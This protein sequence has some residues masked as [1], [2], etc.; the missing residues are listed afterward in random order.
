MHDPKA[1]DESDASLIEESP[2]TDHGEPAYELESNASI[3]DE[4]EPM[5]PPMGEEPFADPDGP[6]FVRAQNLIHEHLAPGVD[7]EFEWSEP[8]PRIEREPDR[9][10]RF[11][12]PERQPDLEAHLGSSEYEDEDEP[13][14]EVRILRAVPDES[15]VTALIADSNTHRKEV[16][17]RVS[18]LFPRPE[19]TEWSVKDVGYDRTRRAQPDMGDDAG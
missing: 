7:P 16:A 5:E 1:F 8:A 13:Q 19:T 18:L 12:L 6:Q 3:E 14:N 9:E 17:S 10:P 2:F 4:S 11:K 15:P